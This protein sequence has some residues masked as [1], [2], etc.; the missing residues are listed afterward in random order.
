MKIAKHIFILYILILHVKVYA[1]DTI[2]NQYNVTIQN[3]EGDESDEEEG[4]FSSWDNVKIN[5]YD[6]KVTAEFQPQFIKLVDDNRGQVFTCP[7]DGVIT[8]HYGYRWHRMHRGTDIDCETGDIIKAAFSGV[9]RIARYHSAFGNLVIIR[10]DNGFETFYAHLSAFLVSEGDNV[11]SGQEIALGG[12]TGR[13]TGSHLHFEM[14]Y[15]GISIDTRKFI[16]WSTRTLIMKEFWLD[17]NYFPSISPSSSSSSSSSSSTPTSTPKPANNTPS[18]TPSKPKPAAAQPEFY[19]VKKG[20][21]LTSIATKNNISVA[22]LCSLNHITGN[23]TIQVGRR[24]KV[25]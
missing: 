13:S 17:K 1:Q 24:L 20:D 18:T 12:N 14:R 15:K 9:V 11:Y 22:K 23:T 2:N 10:H 25:K 21:T 8:S 4:M 6:F 19:T 5:P 7:H 16:N 3:K